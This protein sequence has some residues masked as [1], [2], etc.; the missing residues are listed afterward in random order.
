MVD[1]LKKSPFHAHFGNMNSNVKFRLSKILISTTSLRFALG[2]G[3]NMWDSRWSKEFNTDRTLE[4]NCS[5]WLF[6]YFIISRKMWNCS[7]GLMRNDQP[8]IYP[9]LMSKIH[10]IIR[11]FL[12]G[13]DTISP[14]IQ[15][16]ELIKV[17]FYVLQIWK[18]QAP[19]WP[20]PAQASPAQP[21]GGARSWLGPSVFVLYYISYGIHT[22][23]L[24]YF[25]EN[26]TLRF[27]KPHFFI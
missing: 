5:R 15:E 24:Y 10:K 23:K 20:C 7:F 2:L 9:F 18:I 8:K 14:F 19:A 11:P 16:T 25:W 27:F 4:R 13:Y 26:K 1:Y 21:A 22:E 6:G 17:G 3:Y 12:I